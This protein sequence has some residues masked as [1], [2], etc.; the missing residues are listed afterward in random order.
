MVYSWK[1]YCLIAFA[2]HCNKAHVCIPRQD[3]TNERQWVRSSTERCWV[4][5]RDGMWRDIFF[6]TDNISLRRSSIS[7]EICICFLVSF[8]FLVVMP[9]VILYSWDIF[10]HIPTIIMSCYMLVRVLLH[11]NQMNYISCFNY[12]IAVTR[13]DMTLPCK[14]ATSM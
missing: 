6:N 10:T 3:L 9:P 11:I 13:L 12:S 8:R 5:S 1:T 2:A 14:P 4:R 7:S